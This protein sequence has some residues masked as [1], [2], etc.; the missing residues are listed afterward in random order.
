MPRRSSDKRDSTANLGFEAKLWLAADKLRSNMDAAREPIG[1]DKVSAA[2]FPSEFE[3]SELGHIPKGW[4]VGS[5]LIQADLLS[6][7]TP[8]TDVPEFWNGDIAWASAK[9]VSQCGESFLISTEKKITQR[10]LE[11]SATR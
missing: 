2:L 8:K 5:I 4:V 9:D 3:D 7:G 6:G 1:L 11:K 10:G